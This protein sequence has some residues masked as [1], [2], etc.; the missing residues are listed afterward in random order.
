MRM[1]IHFKTELGDFLGKLQDDIAQSNTLYLIV[2]K[3]IMDRIFRGEK[4]IEYREATEYW[5]KRIVGQWTK[6]GWTQK[7]YDYIRI[8]NGYGNDTRPY[9]LMK[10]PGY[11]R[12]MKKINE[13]KIPTQHYAI[14]ITRDL[15]IEYRDEIGG[16]VKK[17]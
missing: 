9:I 5:E 15:W 17:C 16:T 11:T 14:P 10:Y 3:D 2:Y 4:T 13:D 8:T 12:V 6:T 7:N 1:T